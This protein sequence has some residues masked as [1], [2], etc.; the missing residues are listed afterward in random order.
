MARV[1]PWWYAYCMWNC[2][3]TP[4]QDTDQLC[5]HFLLVRFATMADDLFK[6]K[7]REAE[8]V[9]IRS[10]GHTLSTTAAFTTAWSRHRF[11]AVIGS[12]GRCLTML[13]LAAAWRIPAFTFVRT[14]SSSSLDRKRFP[15]YM[16]H[17]ESTV[18]VYQGPR[19]NHCQTNE[20][21]GKAPLITSFSREYGDLC[22]A[23]QRWKRRNAG[24]RT[25]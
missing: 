23:T 3:L 2:V 1:Y 8:L 24:N 10:S 14:T 7:G 17:I 21:F 12:T 19:S 25:E 4:W 13:E 22:E 20:W 16:T 9:W 11:T 5:D 15:F 6:S 18:P